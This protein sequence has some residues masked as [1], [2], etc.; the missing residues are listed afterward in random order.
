MFYK[1]IDDATEV[2]A[3]VL[4]IG[5]SDARQWVPEFRNVAADDGVRDCPGGCRVQNTVH[6]FFVFF[7]WRKLQLARNTFAMP[8]CCAVGCT[9][10]SGGSKKLFLIPT[11]TRD[12]KRRKEWLRR[13]ARIGFKPTPNSRLCE[14]S[15]MSI[16]AQ[17]L[18]IQ[19][20]IRVEQRLF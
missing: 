19:N 5:T 13:I 20:A 11:G 16:Y 3:P 4:Y 8:S 9:T 18:G 7:F 17:P 6:C 12:A 2:G 10:R 14:A 15:S 1:C